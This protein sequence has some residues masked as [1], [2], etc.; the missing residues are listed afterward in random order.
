MMYSHCQSQHKLDA[1]TDVASINDARALPV[2]SQL[3]ADTD[4]AIRT[5]GANASSQPRP[6]L[7]AMFSHTNTN[8]TNPAACLPA[9]EG[10]VSGW[11][12]DKIPFGVAVKSYGTCQSLGDAEERQECVDCAQLA[13]VYP[14]QALLRG[15]LS[16]TRADTCSQCFDNPAVSSKK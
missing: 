3:N 10:W 16:S 4:P 7:P 9:A 1:D 6:L 12:T 15:H 11:V 2:S 13:A 5:W 8:T 14:V